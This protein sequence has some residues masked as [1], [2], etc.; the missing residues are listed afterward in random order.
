MHIYVFINLIKKPLYR[1]KNIS[2]GA[3]LQSNSNIILMV[4][5]LKR[6]LVCFVVDILC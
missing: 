5:I 3:S 1:N 2:V 4:S 6:P